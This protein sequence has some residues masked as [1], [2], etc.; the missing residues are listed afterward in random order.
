MMSG[1][2]SRFTDDYGTLVPDVDHHGLFTFDEQALGA[3]DGPPAL[4]ELALAARCSA[5]F[6]GAF[7][8]SFVPIGSQIAAGSGV[9]KRPDMALFANMSRSHWAADGGLLANRPLTPLLA[10][11]FSQPATGQVRRVLAF[12][13][14]DGGGTTRTT[15]QEVAE[16]DW[17]HPPTMA[18]ALKAD[19]GAQQSQSI[20]SDLQAARTHNER[21]NARHGVR[22]SLADL[23]SRLRSEDQQPAGSPP[24]DGLVDGRML[25]E[26]ERQQGA[27]LAQPL[28]TEVM[29]QLT[30]IRIPHAWASELA[31]G[32]GAHAEP[33]EMRMAKAMVHSLGRGWH[34]SRPGEP[35][36]GAPAASASALPSS[37]DEEVAAWTAWTA[38]TD[39][40]A[41]AAMFGRPMFLAARAMVIHLIRRGYQ[42]ATD[43]GLRNKL[44]GHRAAIEDLSAL[45]PPDWT[46]GPGRVRDY[47]EQAKAPDKYGHYCELEAVAADL[48]EQ[49]R[50]ALLIGEGAAALRD[51][52]A[53]LAT[54]T[55]SLLAD[56]QRLSAPDGR[57][58]RVDA[59]KA[60][61]VYQR[62]FGQ[63]PEPPQLADR[64]LKLALAERALLPA[65]AELDQPVEFVQ[66]SANTRTL[67]APADDSAPEPQRLDSVA[68]LRGVEFHHFAAFYK[69]SWRA[70]DWMWG[71]L[72]GSGWLVHI[73]LDPRRILA[74]VEDDP[75]A[76]PQGQRAARFATALRDAT[77]L[78]TGLPGDR[79]DQ[80]LAFLD[81]HTAE[82]PVSLP[83]SALFLAQA[84]QNRIAANELPTIAERIIAD[85]GRLPPLIDPRGQHR[86][87]TPA[88]A[89]QQLSARTQ[90]ADSVRQKW[91]DFATSRRN[92]QPLAAP[93]DAWVTNV[94]NLKHQN[95]EPGDFAR[96]LSS[97]PVRQETLAGDLRTPAFARVA[98]KAAAVATA[99]VTA[100]PETPG[101]IRPI[102]TSARTITRTGYMATKLTGGTAWKT[103]LAG[104]VL[105][106]VG[107][108]MATQ[109]MMAVGLTGT[110]VA[111]VGL[112]LIALGAWGIHRGV[113]GALIAIT[114]LAIPALL[115]LHWMRTELWGTGQASN[116][117]LV[118]R[119]VLPWLR[120]SWWGGLAILGG[121]ILIATL[122]SL[123]PRAR[124]PRNRARQMPT[125]TS[126]R[127]DPHRPP[128]PIGFGELS[129]AAAPFPPKETIPDRTPVPVLAGVNAR[130][131]ARAEAI[132]ATMSGQDDNSAGEAGGP[133]TSRG[134]PSGGEPGAPLR[135]SGEAPV[136]GGL[137]RV[138]TRYLTGRCPESV[139]VGEPF[140]LVASIVL[141]AGP[142][143]TALKSFDVPSEGR[144]V[145]LEVYAPGVR[146]LGP[147]LLTVRVPAD[148]DSEP[149]MF[150]LRADEPGVRTV[151]VAAWIAG[152]YLGELRVDI[153][154]ERDRPVGPP[155]D[156][157]TQI[158]SE[159]TEGAVSLVVRFDPRQNA[160]RFEFRDEDNPDE[161]TSS[162]AYEPG[163]RVE[164]LIA[165]LDD[166]A[167]GRSGYSGG[168]A[169]NYL[170]QSGVGLWGE[171]IPPQL[172]QQFWDRQDRIRQLTILADKDAVP[173]ELLY[174]MD[175]GH[176]AGFLVEQ[177]PVTRAIFG[178][179][180][181]RGLSLWPARFVLP[182]GSLP[183]AQAEIDAM[184][185]LLDPQQPPGEVISALTP[186]EDLIARGDFG[187]LH[188]ACHNTYDPAGG[189]SIKLGNVQF[190][191]ML[192]NT[193]AIN[194]GLARSAPTVFINACRSAGLAATYNQLD[195]WANKFLEAG[196]GAFIGSLW[197]VSDGGAREFSEE[198]YGRLKTGFSLGE[199]VK[200]AREAAAGVPD[201][202][203]WLA[204]TVYGD[205]RAT[206]S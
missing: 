131:E 15:P 89:E 70:W 152:S 65:D 170:V 91:H 171:L 46:D 101:A 95:A 117:G 164:R 60:I 61:G 2:T 71:R 30:T 191:P 153:T 108:V 123:I 104:A 22:R 102:L 92:K 44:A 96:Q 196:A 149:V 160:Y 168:Q 179:R 182:G 45:L 118:P 143:S 77:G 200:R 10:K 138:R 126:V 53:R 129:G 82:V 112:Y 151:S 3:G 169:R 180:P 41:R 175:P 100:A 193:A 156:L 187:L 128:H 78:P 107:S 6:P 48:A 148:G 120:S 147:R 27:A 135:S 93:P 172:R 133:P 84:W 39:P 136:G 205:P 121:I 14:P 18:G 161:V 142:S 140:G 51:A 184:R 88:S 124:P 50:Q 4:T 43:R 139:L 181:A 74:V 26:F 56:L 198:L 167:K 162:L 122:L 195:G 206:I 11:V 186:L 111:L 79:L 106:V 134:G 83:N 109:G 81:D 36:G 173:W 157:A 188:F 21:I 137:P 154:A 24:S 73:L 119:D 204:Y 47:L 16:D 144:D 197:A 99:A 9:P 17:A 87:S 7:E 178:R 5:S 130:T 52:W 155:R 31:P 32:E 194:K 49:K 37:A 127:A 85:N 113:L 105:A 8:P 115:T 190:T 76:F 103:L 141:A 165:G 1:E 62:Y 86:P 40:Y 199:A 125:P 97:C 28:L 110:I 64:L 174:P 19:L 90:P 201:D 33:A 66:F 183:Q 59:A 58:S 57:A 72:D 29:R 185:R 25:Q 132:G 80:D 163:P 35:P 38:A 69:S 166:L 189:S 116:S 158:A 94:L 68:K 20:A 145:L 67:L 63:A 159:P 23:G 13:V 150:E 203:T 55:Q 54:V 98:T 42:R 146:L 176:D 177:F 202:P 114:A 75:D 192:M 34:E 12:V